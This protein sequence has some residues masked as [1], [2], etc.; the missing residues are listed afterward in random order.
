MS[1][2]YMLILFLVFILT[3]VDEERGS[4]QSSVTDDDVVDKYLSEYFG[5]NSYEI[6]QINLPIDDQILNIA[7]EYIDT[8]KKIF[9]KAVG[10][11]LKDGLVKAYIYFTVDKIFDSDGDVIFN[12]L[13]HPNE[14]F[15]WKLKLS[16]PKEQSFFSNGFKMTMIS[17]KGN[18]ITDG[19]NIVWNKSKGK[20]LES[21]F[22]SSM[23]D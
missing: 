3:C 18:R 11:V 5:I 9:D 17:D 15:G 4:S 12:A 14:P 16:I 13:D 6:L 21:I 19:P 2:H 23:F 1:K 8:E 7:V 20:F 10:Y 22:D